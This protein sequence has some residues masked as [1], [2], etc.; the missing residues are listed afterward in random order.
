MTQKDWK[1]DIDT[2][3][4]RIAEIVMESNYMWDQIRQKSRWRT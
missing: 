1:Y 3:M 4:F 2:E